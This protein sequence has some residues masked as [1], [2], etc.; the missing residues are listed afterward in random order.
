MSF[1]LDTNILS[2]HLRRPSGLIHRFVQSVGWVVTQQ[3]FTSPVALAGSRPS[4][5]LA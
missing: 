5:Q 3:V 4:L 1:L 2:E